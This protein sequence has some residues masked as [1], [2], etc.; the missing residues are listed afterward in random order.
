MQSILGAL[1][2][3]GYA[4][5]FG[6]AIATQAGQRAPPSRTLFPSPWG[7]AP[8]QLSSKVQRVADDPAGTLIRNFPH[9]RISGVCR[10]TCPIWRLLVN[11]DL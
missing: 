8:P 6:A 3:A 11:L 10:S 9:R 4:A 5:A 2:T 7:G 1:L